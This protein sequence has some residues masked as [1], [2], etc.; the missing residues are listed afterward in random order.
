MLR[1]YNAHDA[2][3]PHASA[4][5]SLHLG[6]PHLGLRDE[7]IIHASTDRAGVGIPLRRAR[8]GLAAVHFLL[9]VKVLS[10]LF[11]RLML[12][13][14]ARRTP[15]PAASIL[16]D[17]R[18]PRRLVPRSRPISQPLIAPNGSS[19]A[20]GRCRARVRCWP[21]CPAT[22]TYSRLQQ[23]PSSPPNATV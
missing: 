16:R 3:I 10:R 21:I 22:P 4:S 14:A 19:I 1:A 8:A 12:A 11:R 2:P 23:P 6:A 5:R 7:P 9:P 17:P 15:I 20:R 13:D 18:P